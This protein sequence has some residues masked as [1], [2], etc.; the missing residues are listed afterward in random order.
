MSSTELLFAVVQRERVV[1]NGVKLSR[2]E[3]RLGKS[4]PVSQ[5]AECVDISM[6][7]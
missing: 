5:R 3:S 6:G 1:T 2:E 4:G 7:T